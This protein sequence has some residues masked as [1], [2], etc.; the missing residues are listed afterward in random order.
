VTPPHALRAPA[1]ARVWPDPASFVWRTVELPPGPAIDPFALACGPHGNGPGV[2]LVSKHL[3]LAG[4]GVAARLTLPSGMAEAGDRRALCEW[5]AALSPAPGGHEAVPGAPHGPV[6]LGALPFAAQEPGSLVVPEL[7]YGR[8]GGREWATVVSSPGGIGRAARDPAEV[9]RCLEALAGVGGA[10]A[11][12][13]HGPWADAPPA[14]RLVALEGP[15]PEVFTSGVRR[16]LESIAAGTV[17]KVVLARRVVA[18]FDVPLDAVDAMRRL[19]RREPAATV[20]G[21]VGA[22]GSFL[23]ASPEVLVTRRGRHV[24]SWPLAG[25]VGLPGDE[26][27]DALAAA[28]LAASDKDAREH[29]QVVDAVVDALAPLC[30]ARPCHGAPSVARLRGVAHLATRV[31]GTLVGDVDVLSLAALLHPTPAVAGT[32][33]GAALELLGALEPHGRGAY[34]GPAGWVD[35]RGDGDFVVAIRGATVV[36]RRAVVHAGAGIVAG[37]DPD[38]ELAETS[39]KLRTAL[40]ALGNLGAGGAAEARP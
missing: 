27:G 20:Y 7:L 13:V 39:L 16:A 34:A 14:R 31:A 19:Q 37:S 9:R 32:P 12:D 2:V 17:S 8:A 5:L 4:H 33:T 26:A 25:T 21:V 24:E 36:G 1:R 35:G 22:T 40:G 28:R 18:A 30:E 6:A 15:A 11:T 38:E 23:G 3:A 10:G 29:G